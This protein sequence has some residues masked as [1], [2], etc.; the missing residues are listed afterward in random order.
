MS[1]NIA[2]TT[3][4]DR[5]PQQFRAVILD[6]GRV[7]CHGP[8]PHELKRMADLLGLTEGQFWAA[9]EKY[10]PAYDEGCSC[11]D[12]WNNMA[13]GSGTQLRPEQ[14]SQLSNWDVEMWT[15]FDQPM[16][17]WA[18][19]LQ[20]AGY[21]TALLSNAP[22][23]FAQYMRANVPWMKAFNASIFSAEVKVIKPGAGIFRRC[24]QQ[25][26][27]DAHEALFVDDVPVNVEGARVAGLSAV[28]FSS[29]SQLADELDALGFQP[30]P[31]LA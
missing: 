12:F 15:H 11:E 3:S 27:V 13:Q 28:L 5:I 19:K 17:D 1:S 14:I 24:L 23:E 30:L 22:L 21:K 2:Q 20:Q 8:Y 31:E 6:Y 18:H 16:L 29:I 7:L 26:G 10:R 4:T 9:F 25:L